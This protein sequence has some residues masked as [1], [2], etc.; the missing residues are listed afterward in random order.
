MYAINKRKNIMKTIGDKLNQ[1]SVVGVKP[2]R[3]DYAEDAFET[4]TEKSFPG[5]WKV[6]VDW[7][8]NGIPYYVE[9][10]VVI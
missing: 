2:A 9:S 6:I 5:K 10:D 7:K 1:F 8:S 3:L 4:L